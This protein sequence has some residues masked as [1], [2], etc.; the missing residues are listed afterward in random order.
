MRTA[1]HRHLRHLREDAGYV[2]ALGG[3]LIVPL[4]IAVGF[5]VD[6]GAWYS[7]AGQLQ[8]VSDAA[9]LGGVVWMPDQTAA[10]SAARTVLGRNGFPDTNAD[11]LVD[12]TDVQ[13]VFQYPE[14]QQFG[15]RLVDPTANL[16]FSSVILDEV[17]IQRQAVAEYILPVAMGSPRNFLGTGNDPGGAIPGGMHENFWLAISGPCASRENGEAIQAIT[18]QNYYTNGADPALNPGP[19]GQSISWSSC[20]GGYTADMTGSQDTYRQEG[21]FY[22]VEVPASAAGSPLYIQVFDAP[23]CNDGDGGY[24]SSQAYDGQNSN[25]G[26]GGSSAHYTRYRVRGPDLNPYRPEDNPVVGTT[27]NMLHNSDTY[28]GSGGSDWQNRWRTLYSTGSAQAGIY[29]VQVQS[30]S[31]TSDANAPSATGSDDYH[32]TNQ[33]SLRASY[34][35]SWTEATSPCSTRASEAGFS[36]NCPQVYAI[37]YMGVYANLGGTSPSFFLAEVGSEHNGKV[38]EI[39]LWDPGEGTVAME[40][41]DPLGR[42]VDFDWEIIDDTGGDTAPT[43][44]W[45]GTVDQPGANPYCTLAWPNCSELD[46][47]GNPQTNYTTSDSGYYRGW[48]PQPGPY[49]GSRSKYSDRAVHIEVELPD[50]IAGEYSGEEWWRVRYTLSPVSGNITDRTTWT[51]NVTGDPIRL[52]E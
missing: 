6:V 51:V 24:P 15:V 21:Y 17:D 19:V 14:A 44:G 47:L 9:S 35:S 43:G 37:D 36:A 26:T 50:D 48:N 28:C 1:L 30:D 10:E 3:L 8:K 46:V 33:F 23:Q 20:T 32:Q 38:L 2:L 18:D 4:M 25:L 39:D 11:N 7:R 29:F 52:I 41:I 13:I 16:F 27:Y 45:T 40:I 34:T 49:R 5:A 12:G 31:D 22:A 42:S